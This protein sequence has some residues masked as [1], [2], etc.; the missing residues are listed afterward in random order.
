MIKFVN[1]IPEL[2]FLKEEF[3]QNRASLVIIYGRRRIGKTTLIKHFIQDKDACYFVATEESER[4]NRR[5]FQHS[6]ANFTGNEFLKKDVLLEWEEIFAEAKKHQS[7]AK[8]VIVLDEFQY[9]GKTR[10]S[11]PSVFQKIWDQVLAD[12]RTMVIL[13]GSL[14]GMMVDQTL[15]YS[16]PLYG[17]RTGQIKMDQI[18]FLDYGEFFDPDLE[19]DNIEYYSVTGGVPKYVELFQPMGDIYEAIEQNILSKRSFLYEEPVFLLEKEFGE[20]G[21][22]FSIIKSIAAG[23]RKLGKIA[24]AL[25]IGQSGLT[26]YLKTLQELDIIAREVPVTEKNPEKSKRGLYHIKD[27]FISFWFKFVH[28]YRSFLEI[29][30][31][32]IV[33]NKIKKHFRENH[34][35]FVYEDICREWL[36]HSGLKGDAGTEILSVGRWWD[37]NTEIDVVGL[38]ENESAIVF[39]E[40]KYTQHATDADTYFKLVEK[41]KLVQ[42]KA[43][44]KNF[45]IFSQSGF[46]QTLMDIAAKQE[47][48]HLKQFNKNSPKAVSLGPAP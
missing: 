30:N 36:L 45:I 43:E 3:A 5:N 21:T 38:T 11:F 19:I 15:A 32:E 17:R 23:N 47:N 41:S 2:R 37:K 44:R 34:V 12:S 33:L 48:L 9:I 28:P 40:C 16:S 31:T 7:G 10:S 35:S 25:G 4:E 24:S 42:T 18:S 13:C 6:V 29:D 20:S 8:K 26:R 22:Y 46:T 39:G 27:N 14:V 1:R